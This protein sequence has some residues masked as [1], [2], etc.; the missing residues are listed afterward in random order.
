MYKIETVKEFQ[1]RCEKAEAMVGELC[2][3]GKTVHYIYPVG[4]Q[5]MEGWRS[6]LIIYLVQNNA[7]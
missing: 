4:G 6:E 3:D 2:R 1:A 7:V 5:Y